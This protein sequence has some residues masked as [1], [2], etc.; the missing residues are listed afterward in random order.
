MSEKRETGH[1]EGK[2]EEEKE[3]KS[4]RAEDRKG[5]PGHQVLIA[6]VFAVPVLKLAWTLGGGGAAGD[7]LL[8]MEPGNWPDVLIGMLM[9]DVLLA[10]VLAIV[11]TRASYAY[12]GARGGAAGSRNLSL[13]HVAATAAVVPVAFGVILG[14]F[15]G[16]WWGLLVCLVAYALRLGV[17]AEYRTGRRSRSDGRRTHTLPTGPGQRTADA[18][19]LLSLALTVLV[20]PVLAVAGALDGQSW[21][22][23]VACDVNTGD[24]TSRAK[25]VE[26]GRKGTGV[27]GWDIA[28]GEVVDG[29]DCGAVEDKTVREP[30]WRG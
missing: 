9:N 21:T 18:A 15:H 23:V 10:V 11:A 5:G 25:L 6:V 7:A 1:K 29:V 8:A 12:F 20:L 26:L 27:V 16:W 24:G 2:K 22:S 28:A 3:E 4:E 13:A 14:A 30:W 17:I 19:W